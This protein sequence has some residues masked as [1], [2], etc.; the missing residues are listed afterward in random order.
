MPVSLQ[1]VQVI[2]RDYLNTVKKK[3]PVF[4]NNLPGWEWG[5]LFISRHPNLKQKVAH[6]ISRS[7]A[8]VDETKINSFFD[9]LERE[10]EGVPPEN[11]YNVD[12]TGYH[13]VSNRKKLLFRR[14]CKHPDIIRN[15]TKSCYTVV[16][17]D[18]A[19]GEI[20]PPYFIFKAK[21]KWSD[22][23][24]GAPAG[25]RMSVTNTGWIDTETYDD[26]FEKH[27]LPQLKKKEGRKILIAD[28]LSSHISLK[29][30]RLCQENNVRLI[31][32]VPNLTHLLQPLDVA[33][34]SQ[35]KAAWRTVLTQWRATSQGKTAVT[36]PKNKFAQLVKKSLDVIEPNSKQNM[37]AGFRCTGIFPTDRK[38]VF[39]KLPSY[40]K[41]AVE[42][43]SAIGES[44]KSFL[45]DLRDSD[46]GKKTR[47]KFQV[48]I[49][50]GKSVSLEELEA[51]YEK[52]EKQ[53]STTAGK[54]GRPQGS[55]NSKVRKTNRKIIKKDSGEV[56]LN[57]KG[58]KRLEKNTLTENTC[59]ENI[60]PTIET[61]VKQQRDDQTVATQKNT[62]DVQKLSN[63]NDL[64]KQF[65]EIQNIDE[66]N[67]FTTTETGSSKHFGPDHLQEYQIVAT[68]TEVSSATTEHYT[69]QGDEDVTIE[70]CI[71]QSDGQL[72]AK[73]PESE[74]KMSVGNLCVFNFEETLFPGRIISLDFPKVSIETMVRCEGGWMWPNVTDVS[75][76]N[77]EDVLRIV[78]ASKVKNNL[79]KY[80][81]DDRLLTMEWGE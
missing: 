51:F 14:K 34:F 20:L 4:K 17:C 69:F 74:K 25:S 1:D 8:K 59:K 73:P 13:D 67:V 53:L 31:M 10:L 26:W 61:N 12:E 64:E 55:K 49:T 63:S 29:V 35:L 76:C 52:R 7:R 58:K 21:Q 22:W 24:V 46:L 48:P 81:I 41:D 23:L 9:N 42:V 43:Q 68:Y 36:L 39:R 44:F 28:N 15:A 77:Y 11:I 5:K 37:A 38:I 70:E 45:T 16:Y 71:V 27:L 19:A 80:I 2:V 79:G 56:A 6:D 54:R 66:D 72:T 65:R 30:S 33:Y 32:L 75:V 47:R 3:I 78:D 57:E 40:G 62:D 18:N 50:A 60:P